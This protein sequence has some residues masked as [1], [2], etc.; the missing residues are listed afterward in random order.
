[1]Q[2]VPLA[3]ASLHHNRQEYLHH[4]AGP[5][6][7]CSEEHVLHELRGEEGRDE[8]R[9]GEDGGIETYTH[10][11]KDMYVGRH[12]HRHQRTTERM[13]TH[14]HQLLQCYHCIPLFA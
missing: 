12:A 14:R 7:V 13:H 6:A 5:A 11:C 10:M 9:T 1:M 4:L 3:H 2:Y 8:G